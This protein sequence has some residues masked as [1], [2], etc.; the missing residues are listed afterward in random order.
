MD[1]SLASTAQRLL[2]SGVSSVSLVRIARRSDPLPPLGVSDHLTAVI[3]VGS[4]RVPSF[5]ANGHYAYP[6]ETVHITVTS[7]EA[8]TVSVENALLD[9]RSIELVAPSFEVVGVGY[10]PDTAY[11]R[12]VHDR[13]FVALRN[14]VRRAFG[15]QPS[16]SP[17]RWI[18]DR[19]S[20]A[21]IVR[22]DGRGRRI[23]VGTNAQTFCPS[24]IEIVRTD[25]YLSGPGTEVLARL[26]L[27]AE[28]DSYN[29]DR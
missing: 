22:F 9:L 5:D 12:C 1:H 26:R 6:P 10:S 28:A 3:R 15:V 27:V 14:E 17:T 11:L 21:N 20:F 19:I 7:L 16:R 18:F 2:H 23:E 25:R 4:N 8:A 24:E 29:S 13:A